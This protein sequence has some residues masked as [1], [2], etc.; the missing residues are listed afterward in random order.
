M[1]GPVSAAAG[2]VRRQRAAAEL[3]GRPGEASYS[4]RRARPRVPGTARLLVTLPAPSRRPARPGPPRR[5][6]SLRRPIPGSAAAPSRSPPRSFLL[7]RG[8]SRPRPPPPARPSPPGQPGPART[9]GPE[10]GRGG[11]PG[12]PRAEGPQP[13][14]PR[15]VGHPHGGGRPARG[16]GESRGAGRPVPQEGSAKP[17]PLLGALGQTLSRPRRFEAGVRWRGAAAMPWGSRS[18]SP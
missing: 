11:S 6:A 4:G 9:S 14:P 17:P 5:A 8:E 12:P 7:R 16:E 13:P 10:P 18:R 15:A 2:P 1:P 3:P